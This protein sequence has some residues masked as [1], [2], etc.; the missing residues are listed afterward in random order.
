MSNTNSQFKQ[1]RILSI[2][3]AKITLTVWSNVA[4]VVVVVVYETENN[5]T[6][7]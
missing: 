3:S 7:C 5:L 2:S 4:V 6:H 1:R